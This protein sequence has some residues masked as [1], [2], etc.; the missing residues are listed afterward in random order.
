MLEQ[1]KFKKY[2]SYAVGEI[3]LIVVGILIALQISNYHEERKERQRERQI[4]VAL[5]HELDEDIAEIDDV[6]KGN[7]QLLEELDELLTLIASAPSDIRQQR[8]LYILSVK[9]TYWYLKVEFSNS[10]LAQL[11]LSGDFSLIQDPAMVEKIHNYD[12]AVTACEFVYH[13]LTGYFH[14][15]EDS[16]KDLLNLALAKRAYEFIEQD[17]MNMLL[18]ESEFEPLVQEG[19][20]FSDHDPKALR[21]YYGDI[22]FYRTAL[23]NTVLLSGRTQAMAVELRNMIRERYDI[24]P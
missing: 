24:R 3:I 20:Y 9:S 4:L 2:L 13:M 17:Y 12:Q 5:T 18:P 11:K 19:D 7:T 6:V 22:L 1:R 10:T 15:L 8:N 16:Q 21:D 14:V 23:N